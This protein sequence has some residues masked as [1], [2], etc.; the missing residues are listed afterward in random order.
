MIAF[1]EDDHEISDHR[2]DLGVKGH[3]SYREPPLKC[4]K[5]TFD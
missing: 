1:C 2:Y 5:M 4:P 3:G